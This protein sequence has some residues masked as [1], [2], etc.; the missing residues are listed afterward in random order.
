MEPSLAR[1]KVEQRLRLTKS[2]A[3]RKIEC[4]SACVSAGRKALAAPPSLLLDHFQCQNVQAELLVDV[5]GL[6]TVS[7]VQPVLKLF[8][9]GQSQP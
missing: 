2:L 9:S 1:V 5:A 3:R 6:E 8:D 4:N 7:L